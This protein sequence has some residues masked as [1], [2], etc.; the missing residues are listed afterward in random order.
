[1]FAL[2]FA[3]LFSLTPYGM[4]KVHEPIK[5]SPTNLAGQPTLCVRPA[6]IIP[7]RPAP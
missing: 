3:M 2:L 1:M 7:L 4:V 5:C 6:P